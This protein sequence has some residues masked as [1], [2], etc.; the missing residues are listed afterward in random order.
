MGDVIEAVMSR[1]GVVHGTVLVEAGITRYRLRAAVSAGVLLSP[2][3]GWLALPDADPYLVAAARAGVVLTCVTQAKRRGLWVLAEDGPHVAAPPSAS[4]LK[5]LNDKTTVHWAVPVQPRPFGALEDGILNTLT[6]V[7]NC[8]P[9]EAA[10]AVWNSALNGGFATKQELARLP[11]RPAARRLLEA[12]TPFADSGLETI[13]AVRLKWLR[14]PLRAQIW[15]GGHR[16]DFL[17][18]ERLVVQ[19]DGGHHV[20]AQRAEDVAHDAALMLMGYHTIRVTYVQVIERWHEV[21]DLIMH[22]VAQGLHRAA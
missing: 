11:M 15:I 1:G 17:L 14:L 10:L 3:R 6:A 19:V 4:R 12:V 13:F 5:L 18:G 16:V 7:A 9:F 2:R 8:Q 20:G 21:Q 22:A